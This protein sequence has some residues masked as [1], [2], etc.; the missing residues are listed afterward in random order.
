MDLSTAVLFGLVAIIGI[1]QVL[2]RTR[3]AREHSKVFWGLTIADLLAGIAVLV[4]GLPGFEATPVVSWVVGLLLVMHVA[5]NL[6]LRNQWEQEARDDA[7]AARDEERKQRR[8]DREAREL[9]E[10]ASGEEAPKA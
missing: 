10:A 5:Q 6:M 8:Q 1:N 9:E 4:L 7:R 3:V 2:V